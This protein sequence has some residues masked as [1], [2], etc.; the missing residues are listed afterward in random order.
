MIKE[1]KRVICILIIICLIQL[2]L[3]LFWASKK[4]Y[5]FLDELFSY[6][7]SNRLEGTAAELPANE[8]LD[9]GWFLDYVS[10]DPEHTF[11]YAIP[12]K[13]QDTDVHPP[14]FY[15]FLHTAC[16]LIPGKFSYWAGTGCNILFFLGCTLVLYGLGKS[17]FQDRVLGLLSAFLFAISYGGL[18]TMVFIRM[19]ML[20][21]LLVLL[22]TYV[23]MKYLEQEKVPVKG[24]VFLS[25]TLIAGVLTQY[26]FVIIAFFY[27]AWYTIKFLCQ[28]QYHKLG[29]YLVSILISAG[30]SIGIYPMMLQ[31][32]FHTG[33]GVEARENFSSSQGYLEKL[34]TMWKL[35]D[36]Q[37]FFNLFLVIFVILLILTVL[38][39]RD[40]KDVNRELCGKLSAILFACAGYFLIVT[41]IAPYQIDRYLMPIYPLVYMVVVGAVY[42]LAAKMIP[43]KATAV[44]CILGFGGLSMIH[45]GYSAIPHTYSQ[46]V[47]I[48]PRLAVAEEYCEDYAIYIGKREEDIPKYY[49]MI[50]V[51]SK[52]RGYYYIDSLENVEQVKHDFEVL[53]NEDQ[54]VL[55]IDDN[56]KMIEVKLFLEEIF[57]GSVL[58]EESL[59]HEDE[60][61]TVYML[62]VGLGET[63]QNK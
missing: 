50:Q 48:T 39:L 5:L 33:R 8:W 1:K 55:Y 25:L 57:K 54:V 16:S 47:I 26:Y 58:D 51:M 27:G 3:S 11:D 49:N 15:L 52:Y 40:Q 14:L 38:Y 34:K 19:Y 44:L 2:V 45:M 10:V 60:N 53:K 12:Y 31:H 61:W 23:Y 32:V 28:K 13:N 18:N 4:S 29:K 63:E 17:L 62:D 7:T 6:A 24:Y 22:H 20:L 59:L 37:L 41:K 36:S 9:E 35:M 30:C 42:K 56:M 43:V 21:T 46:D